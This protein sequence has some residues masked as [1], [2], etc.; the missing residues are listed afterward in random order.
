M[1]EFTI[2]SKLY[3]YD[4][5]AIVTKMNKDIHVLLV[6]GILPHTGSVHIYDTGIELGNIQLPTHKDGILGSI[7]AKKI[8]LAFQC[9][10][11]VV[12]GVH[13]D[14]ATSIMLEEIVATSN[15][16]LKNTIM[17]LTLEQAKHISSR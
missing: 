3:G 13:Y 16:M 2:Q 7:W 14:N 5:K 4:I 11:C 12:C 15:Q 1:K 9:K 8:S 6:G 17:E 10:T